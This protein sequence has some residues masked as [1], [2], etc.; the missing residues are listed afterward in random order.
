MFILH[1]VSYQTKILDQLVPL[2]APVVTSLAVL[3]LLGAELRET[4]ARMSGQSAVTV[5]TDLLVFKVL[6]RVSL[7]I[8][9]NL[10]FLKPTG[11]YNIKK[12]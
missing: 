6:L 3:P 12:E 11:L 4:G 9:L 7:T 2:T 5:C 1:G 8:H 10:R